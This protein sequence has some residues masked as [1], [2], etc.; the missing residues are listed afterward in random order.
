[1]VCKNN[2]SSILVKISARDNIFNGLHFHS[3]KYKLILMHMTL[4]F[5]ILNNCSHKAD[6]RPSFYYVSD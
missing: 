5:P 4:G 2:Y 3:G 1:M 6:S